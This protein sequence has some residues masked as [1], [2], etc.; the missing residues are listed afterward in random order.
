M[1]FQN[2]ALHSC[3]VRR[4]LRGGGPINIPN[5]YQVPEERF[6]LVQTFQHNQIMVYLHEFESDYVVIRDSFDY[7]FDSAENLVRQYLE[8][9][10]NM[11]IK[12][13][14]N[15]LCE[16]VQTLAEV[17][18][19][20]HSG[21]LRITNSDWVEHTLDYACDL[22]ENMFKLLTQEQSGL[23]LKRVESIE[24]KLVAYLPMAGT[25]FL[26]FP[27]KNKR[28]YLNPKN[29][30][31][32][33]FAFCVLVHFY[34]K[35]LD[36]DH[37]NKLETI[38]TFKKLLELNDQHRRLDLSNFM[39][40]VDLN[41]LNLFEQINN[42]SVT[43]YYYF[44][45]GNIICPL[46]QTESM[47]DDHI[48][49]FLIRHG[50]ISEI[51]QQSYNSQ[52]HYC[53]I[54][55][56]KAFFRNKSCNDRDICRFCSNMVMSYH[57]KDH[58]SFCYDTENKQMRFPKQTHYKFTDVHKTMA[59]PYRGYISILHCVSGG[60][61]Q[62]MGYNII[63]VN[64][65]NK[66]IED[67]NYVAEDA[68]K[69][70]PMFL[71]HVCNELIRKN[72]RNHLPLVITQKDKE[73]KQNAKQC[74]LKGCL[75]TVNNPPIYHHDH[76]KQEEIIILCNR[77][78]LQI[79][80]RCFIYFVIDNT[81][82][83]ALNSLMLSLKNFYGEK[84]LLVP[85]GEKGFISIYV[86][87]MFRILCKNLFF[88]KD[89]SEL[90]SE[91]YLDNQQQYKLLNEQ[92]VE[93]WKNPSYFPH[94]HFCNVDDMKNCV[95]LPPLPWLNL[96]NTS[97]STNDVAN[98]HLLFTQAKCTNMYDFAR[99]YLRL[100]V[101]SLFTS[102]DLFATWLTS[103]Y[104][105]SPYHELTLSSFSWNVAFFKSGASY[106]YVK[107]PEMIRNVKETIV[108][109]ISY[110]GMFEIKKE[111]TK[112]IFSCDANSL[113]QHIMEGPLPH[114]NYRFL[115]TEEIAAF[116]VCNVPEGKGLIIN[117]DL[118]YPDEIKSATWKLPL[119][120]ERKPIFGDSV[121]PKQLKHMKTSKLETSFSSITQQDKTNVSL[122]HESLLWNIQHGMELKKINWIIEFSE[123][124]YLAEYI[125]FN[126]DLKYKADTKFKKSVIKLIGNTLYGL[127]HSTRDNNSIIFASSEK[128]VYRL[129]SKNTFKDVTVINSEL[130]MIHMASPTTLYH[131]NLLAAFVILD[132]SRLHMY[133]AVYKLQQHFDN[134]VLASIETD[135]LVA[136][137][138]D[139]NYQQKLSQLTNFLDFSTF[140]VS[141]PLYSTLNANQGGYFKIEHPH[142]IHFVK[143]HGKCYAFAEECIKCKSDPTKAC[144]ECEKG[145]TFTYKGVPKKCT[146]TF[147][148]YV[149]ALQ[150][151]IDYQES[152]PTTQITLT[153]EVKT[154]ARKRPTMK[155][156]LKDRIAVPG[157]S[158]TLPRGYNLEQLPHDFV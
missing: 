93:L 109:P 99:T 14:Y 147:L 76:F 119:V 27:I 82:E 34:M 136:L 78:N 30:D 40:K 88:Q 126:M 36:V 38:K 56:T 158:A 95:L 23:R 112:N 18:R 118:H 68:W 29:K 48:S 60:K 80:S 10:G 43:V 3:Q 140:P 117:C 2:L 139:A 100:Q 26:P 12:V 21:F 16:D 146:C 156:S 104:G 47:Y 81:N 9:A 84:L 79:K 102:F 53:L 90:L 15:L 113:Y 28:G 127:F 107:D 144:D 55:N 64:P 42:V 69:Q 4:P 71:I 46:R 51:Q 150:A 20:F 59:P 116:D 86:R 32:N 35:M 120:P 141:S 70:F 13:L 148:E 57:L 97:V 41:M 8:A 39:G 123:E 122:Y 152:F 24:I 129:T 7:I 11:Q 67:I 103:M 106:E 73:R 44:K 142:A 94:D 101:L 110:H 132:K 155:S 111:E 54:Y 96:Y 89:T 87:G 121:S 63:G 143:I 65:E 108:G 22:I 6:R 137:V 37:R 133:K 125:K 83:V 58:E 138:K 128:H 19:F 5:E 17:E 50:D 61:V 72:K 92:Y 105:L 145:F 149:E 154:V 31:E 52:G 85:H 74:E 45:K 135:G 157:Y 124:P 1:V 33:C 77:C 62:I 130:A 115:T 25:S 49:L 91:F 66:I 134:Y 153:G 151:N 114:S 131:R 75:F 98:M